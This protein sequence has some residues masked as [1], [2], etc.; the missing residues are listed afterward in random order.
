MQTDALEKM[1]RRLKEKQIEVQD[2]QRKCLNRE[3]ESTK[4][5]TQLE[6]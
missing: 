1:N 4:K 3:Q 2:W 6:S 5:I